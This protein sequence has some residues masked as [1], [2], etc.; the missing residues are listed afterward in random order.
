MCQET[1]GIVRDGTGDPPGSSGR[2]ERS[3]NNSRT[4]RGTFNEV[5]DRSGDHPEDP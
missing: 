1:L 5:R 4:G 2:V 3:S